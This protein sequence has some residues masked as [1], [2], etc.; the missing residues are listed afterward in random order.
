MVAYEGRSFEIRLTSLSSS[1]RYATPPVGALFPL[2]RSL[3]TV[4]I[5]SAICVKAL[6]KRSQLDR[7]HDETL[8][9]DVQ[10]SMADSP[11]LPDSQEG[12]TRTFLF[13]LGVLIVPFGIF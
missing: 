2:V 5:L 9:R 3:Y 8:G 12:V 4:S 1:E 11:L 7:K 6:L 10:Y 13:P